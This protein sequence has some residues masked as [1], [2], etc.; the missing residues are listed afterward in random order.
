MPPLSVPPG[1]VRDRVRREPP[2]LE[3]LRLPDQ[4]LV[5]PLVVG[6]M[7]HAPHGRGFS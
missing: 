5:D 1:Q 4:L 2:S 3:I 7:E 6:P